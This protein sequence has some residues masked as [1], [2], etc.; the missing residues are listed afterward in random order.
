MILWQIVRWEHLANF[1]LK[2]T[3]KLFPL[4]PVEPQ[5]K[6]RCNSPV[7]GPTMTYSPSYYIFSDIVVETRLL[8]HHL[9]RAILKIVFRKFLYK[10]DSVFHCSG[11]ENRNKSFH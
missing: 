2:G 8:T 6:N 4:G 3:Q 5:V 11:R 7:Y 10:Q 1:A 9:C